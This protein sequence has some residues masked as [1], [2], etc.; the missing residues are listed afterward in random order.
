VH[1]DDKVGVFLCVDD[2]RV[3]RQVAHVT[4]LHQHT[5]T[6]RVNRMVNRFENR[7]LTFNFDGR[8][9]LSPS[10]AGFSTC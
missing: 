4:Q 10:L 6:R 8:T 7:I 1:K 5:S 2:L 9:I 3:G